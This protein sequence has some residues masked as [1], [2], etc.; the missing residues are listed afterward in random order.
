MADYGQL[1]LQALGNYG[2]EQ[3]ARAD[4]ERKYQPNLLGSLAGAL[5][6]AVSGGK[7]MEDGKVNLG[8]LLSPET[9]LSP[10]AGY[11]A[12]A[13]GVQETAG[14]GRDIFSG[15]RAGIE[16][17]QKLKALEQAQAKTKQKIAQEERKEKREELKLEETI[18]HN[19]AQESGETKS[20]GKLKDNAF[21]V[22]S[23]AVNQAANTKNLPSALKVIQLSNI[24]SSDKAIILDKFLNTVLQTTKPSGGLNLESLF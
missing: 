15:L 14:T 17:T 19:K 9:W 12:V 1:L 21:A 3:R 13:G 18:R 6:G 24:S 8:K 11:G 22:Y 20:F 2:Q 16:T 4:I 10:E 7:L 23:R 5:G